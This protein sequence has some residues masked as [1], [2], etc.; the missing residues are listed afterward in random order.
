MQL[1]RTK[2]I[3]ISTSYTT[4]K[5][6]LATILATTSTQQFIVLLPCL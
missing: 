2:N 1:G 4:L 6:V 5:L 3:N